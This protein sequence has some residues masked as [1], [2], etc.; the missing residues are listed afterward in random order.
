M[1]HQPLQLE[2]SAVQSEIYDIS[3]GEVT[4]FNNDPRCIVGCFGPEASCERARSFVKDTTGNNN[5][6]QRV[7]YSVA[8]NVLL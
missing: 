7:P 4:I 5:V 3:S 2:G 8:W 1:M 6:L